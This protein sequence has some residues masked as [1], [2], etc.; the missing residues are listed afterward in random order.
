MWAQQTDSLA[1]SIDTVTGI[2]KTALGIDS[3]IVLE[4]V[5]FL[6]QR[7]LEDFEVLAEES[8]DSEIITDELEELLAEYEFH[9]EQPININSEE[10]T[11]LDEMGLLSAFQIEALRKYRKWYGDLLYIE[12]L[13]MVEGFDEHSVAVITPIVYC[14]KSEKVQEQER[15]TW[16]KALT[17]GKHQL[18]LNYAQKIE[19]S[20]AYDEASDSLLMAKPNTYYLGN[21]TKLQIKYGY[22]YGTH[23]RFGIAMEKDAGEPFLFGHLSDTIKRLVDR[24]PGFDFYGLYLYAT[25]MKIRKDAGHGA[26]GGRLVIKDLAIGDY[27][28]SFGQGLTLWS[29]MSLGKTSGS[30]SLMK[31]GAGVRPKASAGEGKFFRGIATTLAFRELEATAFYSTRR[32]DATVVETDS[33]DNN[34]DELLD[35]SDDPLTVSALQET[36]YHRSLGELAKR[37]TLRQQVFGGRLAYAGSQLEIGGT[38]YHLRL[39]APLLLKPSKYNQFFF[40]GDRL[41]V[42]GIDFRW[43]LNKAVFY[44]ELSMSD[45]IA[46]AGLVGLTVKPKGYID[47]TLMYRNFGTQYQNL[48]FGAVKES[49]RGQAEESF[50][51][52]LHCAPAPSWDLL[53]HCDLFRFKWLTSQVYTP[54]WGQEYNLQVSHQLSHNASM[55]LKIKS[56]TKMKNSTDNHVF[57]YYPIFYTKRSVQFQL[58]YTVRRQWILSNKAS[59]SHYFNDDGIDSQGVFICQDVSF[60]PDGRPYSLTF[61]YALYE[62]DDYNSRISVYE[63]DVLGAFSIPSLYGKGSRFYLLGKL[64]LFN[65]LSIYARIGC[66]FLSEETRTDVKAEMIWKF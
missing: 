29:G 40:Q 44:G 65:A 36:G 31:R 18:T 49:S 21:P 27:Q 45:N 34:L 8:E 17:R 58:S 37:H 24:S 64:K 41:T 39:S 23:L 13:M 25:D 52:G 42:T 47:F 32:I 57:S 26:S 35:D 5:D 55:Q 22:S 7:I 9:R 14:G 60:K 33:I 30:S 2:N 50:Y 28:L 56:K 16:R 48:F 46:F 11:Q 66:S 15:L 38:A 43:L 53:A 59:Y 20:E 6:Y 62:S 63:N 54:S 10:I 51:L 61:R 4:H 3:L 12:E 19:E 1:T